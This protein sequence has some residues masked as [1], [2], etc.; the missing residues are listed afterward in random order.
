MP[1]LLAKETTE[2]SPLS[3]ALNNFSKLSLFFPFTPKFTPKFIPKFLSS[4]INFSADKGLRGNITV[5]K[6]LNS[7]LIG[8]MGH[9]EADVMFGKVKMLDE[10]YTSMETENHVFREE[11]NNGGTF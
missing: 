11:Y 7:N 6:L 4:E 8:S 10:I 3:T 2:K 5:V 1:S 9:V